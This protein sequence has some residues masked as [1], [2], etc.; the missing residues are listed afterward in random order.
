MGC[1]GGDYVIDVGFILVFIVLAIAFYDVSN[2]VSRLEH[3]GEKAGYN[4]IK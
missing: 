2:V 1:G 3:L 4:V